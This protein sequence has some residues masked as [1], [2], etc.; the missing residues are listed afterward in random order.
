MTFFNSFFGMAYISMM[1]VFAVDIL[2]VGADGQGVLMS[3]GGVGALTVTIYL[4]ARGSSQHRGL[5]IIGGAVLFGLAVAAFALTSRY[6]SSYSLAM[7]L[8]VVMGMSSSVYMISIMSSLQLL[9]PNN[10]RGR[11]M[12][13][14]GMTWSIMPL[15][16]FL[17]AGAGSAIGLP[18]AIAAGGLLVSGFALGP[19]LLNRKIRTIGA[20]LAEAERTT[21]STPSPASP[22]KATGAAAGDD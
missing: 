4:G 3:V 13:F 1:P 15:G 16:G 20:L 22:R 9:V 19:A 18:F 6:V 7:A 5:L 14:Y 8:I 21:A 10:M 2:K 12:G 17:A 11:V